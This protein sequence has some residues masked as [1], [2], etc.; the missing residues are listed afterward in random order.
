MYSS[1]AVKFAQLLLSNETK[2]CLNSKLKKLL[3][4]LHLVLPLRHFNRD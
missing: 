2:P 4:C 3:I 1:L